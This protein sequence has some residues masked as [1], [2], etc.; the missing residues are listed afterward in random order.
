M[1]EHYNPH[2]IESAIQAHWHETKR[3]E[4]NEDISTEKYYCLA[5]MPYPSGNLHMGHVRNYTISD[6]IARY[7]YLLGKNV[8]QPIA[9]D[10]FGLP[11]ENAAIKHKVPPARWT[12][13]NISHM[14]LQLKALG[15]AYDWSREITTCKPSYYRWE[16]WFFTKLYET[17]LVYQKKSMVN[18]DPVDQTV[19]AN[20]QVV[21]G[22]G[23]RS[24][25]LVEKREI[26]QWFL[27]ITDYAQQLLD[28]LD[29]LEHWPEQVKTMQRNWIGRS[30]GIDIN[31]AINGITE[32]LSVYTTRPDTLMGCTFVSIAAKHP[33]ALAAAEKNHL[34]QDFINS[35][36]KNDVSEL[37]LATMEKRG[38]DTGFKA[39]HPIS[40]KLIPV[41]VANFVLMD[42]G[43]GAVMSVPSHDQRDFEFAT[44]YNIPM[45]QVLA[46]DGW[47][48]SKAA[49]IE[50]SLLINSGEFDGLDF[51]AAFNHIADYLEKSGKGQRKINFRLRDWG[52]SRQRYWGTPIPIIYCDDC[53]A[54]AVPEKDLPVILPEDFTPDGS[55]SPLK[56]IPEF[57]QTTCP[58]CNKPATR[59]TDTFDTF[60]ESSWYYARM[61][62]PDQ[63]QKMLDSR[64]NYWTP[65]N[66]YVGGIEH[67][68][69]HLL[70]ARFFHKLMRDHGL[71]NSDEP[72]TRLLTQGMVLKDGTKM[73]KSKG[74]VIDPQ[75][76]IDQY[77]ADTVRLFII[78]AAPPE[79][80]LE[81]SDTGVEGSHKF[82]RRLWNFAYQQADTIRETNSIT[83]ID[84]EWDTT[85][86]ELIQVRKNIYTILQQ[87]SNDMQRLQLNTVISA[88]M[89]L[90]NL[91]Q[92]IPD[93]IA[94]VQ[95]TCSKAKIVG[96][97]G[98]HLINS[99]LSILLRML[100]SVTPHICQE[101]WQSL[102]YG[103]DILT[104]SWPKID[105]QALKL[106]KIEL[107]VQVNGKL[108]DKIMV[109]TDTTQASIEQLALAQPKIQSY[110]EGKTVRKVILVP[111]RLINI[112]VG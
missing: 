95:D 76:L 64:V 8:M 85:A 70:Y 78:F 50:K 67:A 97:I 39:V 60:M 43:T 21:D 23:W 30:E 16:Q 100:S 13:D 98:A 36:D 14:R 111:N 84:I 29:E 38:I 110:L 3:F 22:R 18:W 45:Q 68:V 71:L 41:W 91:L 7:Q 75:S 10:A 73:S 101:L 48:F 83:P 40:G 74:N 47:D 33:L 112:V 93:I 105:K 107:M 11:A 99:G 62:C 52:V 27:K 9:W 104:S 2:Q 31:F 96:N 69:M 94:Q 92:E 56:T 5:M 28:D 51:E 53:G 46:A 103:D 24:G 6:V 89:K 108:R 17:G 54:V 1:N 63:H 55:Q 19:L 87:A 20:E 44:S 35:C 26:L 12:Y 32:S 58:K 88:A 59:E 65:V 34:I 72:F 66:Q 37:T 81:W 109:S 90:L 79:Q 86:D 82:L 15:I 106:N 80:S 61:A 4:A 102:D 25:A 49:Y 77:G 57:Y 42:Y